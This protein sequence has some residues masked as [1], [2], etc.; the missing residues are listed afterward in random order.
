MQG[1]SPGD[2]PLQISRPKARSWLGGE[3]LEKVLNLLKSQPREY[4]DYLCRLRLLLKRGVRIIPRY[5]STAKNTYYSESL[6]LCFAVFVHY[7]FFIFSLSY[8]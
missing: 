5:R 6:Q 4:R 3:I 7:L 8:V 1:D 2:R